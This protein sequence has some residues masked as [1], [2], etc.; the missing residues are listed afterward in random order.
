M[1]PKKKRKFGAARR[2]IYEHFAKYD[3]GDI[4]NGHVLFFYY[5]NGKIVNQTLDTLLA[6]FSGG[7]SARKTLN[8][9]KNLIKHSDPLMNL[10]SEQ[11][12]KKYEDF[13][14]EYFFFPDDYIPDSPPAPVIAADHGAD[15]E[16]VMSAGLPCLPTP[17]AD[18]QLPEPVAEPST[19]G[20]STRSY[21]VSTSWKAKMKRRLNVVSASN[22]KMKMTIRELRL[23]LKV[24]Q[25][26]VNRSIMR[27][28]NIIKKKDE[29]ISVLKEKLRGDPLSIELTNTKLELQ[30]LKKAHRE[31]L[32]YNKMKKCSSSTVSFNKY[33]TPQDQFK[34]NEKIISYLEQENLLLQEEIDTCMSE[35]A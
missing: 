19:S 30:K 23:R 5:E 3:D 32:K 26:V 33:A 21:N 10:Y 25:R 4:K 7:I 2:Y 11:Q 29:E 13:C 12:M 8:R 35:I 20:I 17:P 27:K 31:L 9:I 24:P 15:A 6:L 22:H 18:I 14:D 34:R 1:P 28:I 16:P